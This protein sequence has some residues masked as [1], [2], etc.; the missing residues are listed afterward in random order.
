MRKSRLPPVTPKDT[1][2][3]DP[4]T[5]GGLSCQG[6]HTST[7]SGVNSAAAQP[8]IGLASVIPF[9]RKKRQQWEKKRQIFS[10]LTFVSSGSCLVWLRRSVFQPVWCR[11]T[12]IEESGTSVLT[13]QHSVNTR[14]SF[15]SW[16]GRRDCCC[17]L[18]SLLVFKILN[19]M[20]LILKESFSF[21]FFPS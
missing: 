4:S 5:S 9:K 16:A 15:C 2:G 17:C 7:V 3:C 1:L 8:R 20:S 13:L 19:N 21:P 10:T 18:E 6:P 14:Q 11:S 12:G